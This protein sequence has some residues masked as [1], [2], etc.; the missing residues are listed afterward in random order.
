MSTVQFLPDP[1]PPKPSDLP[2]QVPFCPGPFTRWACS[3]DLG[4][5]L[6]IGAGV[7]RSFWRM[8]NT[9][10]R[11]T[12]FNFSI[13]P[14]MGLGASP[15]ELK[16]NMATVYIHGHGFLWTHGFM[17]LGRYTGAEFLGHMETLGLTFWGTTKLF[18]SL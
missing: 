13:H 11:Q 4:L 7:R 9:Q 15:L 6:H 14:Y 8:N 16:V 10:F 12:S 2:C 5:C 17:P 1:H 18:S 3:M